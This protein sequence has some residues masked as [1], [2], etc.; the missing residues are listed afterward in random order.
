MTDK[1][2]D[3]YSNED[4]LE[5]SSELDGRGDAEFTNPGD[6]SVDDEESLDEGLLDGADTEFGVEND[7]DTLQIDDPDET[8]DD[9][10]DED[11]EAESAAELG[12]DDRV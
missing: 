4:L 12:D 6:P 11:Y 3:E 7:I 1:E 2:R 8:N 5:V 10:D 9:L